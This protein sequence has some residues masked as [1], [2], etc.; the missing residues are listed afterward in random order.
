VF[1]GISDLS[2]DLELLESER[3]QAEGAL[4]EAKENLKVFK[5]EQKSRL[6]TFLQTK[7]AAYIEALERDLPDI[8]EQFL[9]LYFACAKTAGKL[10]LAA[11]TPVTGGSTVVSAKIGKFFQDLFFEVKARFLDGT[12]VACP[13]MWA[14]NTQ[15]VIWPLVER[16]PDDPPDFISNL[17]NS[18]RERQDA[19]KKEFLDKEENL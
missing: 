16:K 4:T 17:K 12:T 14:G 2:F 9:F 5:E 1:K 13:Q 10:A 7:E 3:T 6:E 19:F 11:S 8:L 18:I 15:I